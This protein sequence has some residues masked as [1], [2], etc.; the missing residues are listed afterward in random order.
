MLLGAFWLV[1]FSL[2]LGFNVLVRLP[3]NARTATDS[4]LI[5][6]GSI[7]R[8]IHGAKLAIENP[9]LPILIARGSPDPCIYR[10]FARSN[11]PMDKVWLEVCSNSTFGNFVFALPIL[12][13]WQVKKIKLVTSGTH[14]RRSQWLARIMLGSH[15]IWVDVDIAPEKGI[16]GNQEYLF[17]TVLD[18]SRGVAW[19]FVSQLFQ[20]SCSQMYPLKT[21]DLSQWR[22]RNYACERQ[23]KIKHERFRR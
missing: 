6:G 18:L 3:L 8:E 7:S 19:S 16:P 23:G 20:P 12:K 13:Q 11:A 14:I 2:H 15:G 1:V 21:I 4:I 5:L 10:V 9:S 17:K 22:D